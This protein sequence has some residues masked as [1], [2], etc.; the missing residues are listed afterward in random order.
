DRGAPRKSDPTLL[1]LTIRAARRTLAVNPDDANAYQLLGRAYHL[2]LAT[3]GK[4]ERVVPLAILRHVQVVTA[5]ESALVLRPDLEVAHELLFHHYLEW[6]S[7]DRWGY[8][9]LALEHGRA[10][11]AGSRVGLT[12]QAVARLQDQVDALE[13]RVSDLRYRFSVRIKEM[14][15][16]PLQRALL[17]LSM[18]LPGVALNDVLLR[19]QVV[20]FGTAGA[21][22]EIDLLL[23]T[24]QAWRARA[25]LHEDSMR[26][27]RSK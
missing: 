22:L 16:D 23:R 10:R 8:F 7:F 15:D 17:A 6:G 18:G 12:E 14:G 11:L 4:E 9:D 13:K 25:L 24:G 3:G 26:A 21:R 27:S 1:L 19:S 2:L 20:L 5:L